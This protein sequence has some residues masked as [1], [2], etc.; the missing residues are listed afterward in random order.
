MM[1][2]NLYILAI[3]SLLSGN[4]VFAQDA[5]KQWSLEECIQYAIE[6][7]IDLKQKEQEQESRKVDLHTSKYSWLPALNG[8]LGQSFQFGRSTS[9]SGVIVDQNAANSTLG[10]NLDMPL[11]DGLKIPNDIAARKLDLK[12]SIENLNKAREDLSINIA[13]YYLQV[14]YNKELLK[15]A[16]LQVELDKEQVNKTFRLPTEAEWEYAARGGHKSKHYKYSGSNQVSEVA[17]YVENSSGGQYGEAGTTRP[18]GLKKSNE[19][20]LYDMSGNVW[21]WCGDLYTKEYKQGGKSIHP[22]W[23]FEGTYL[24]F[25]R[26]LRGGSWG[27]TAKG[28]RVSYIDYDIEN[29][30]D[31]YGG[32][33]LVMELNFSK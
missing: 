16:Q 31:E 17:W 29:Y 32:F 5:V 9:K 15:I 11:F 24:F 7:N 14:L 3:A 18:V 12:A 22:G 23:P 1:R 28:C 8:S 20:G 27:G 33:R 2:R 30:S 25:R 6:H 13:S 21:E 4:Y 19:L 26:I 10:I